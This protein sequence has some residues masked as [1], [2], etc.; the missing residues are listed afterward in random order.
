MGAGDALRRRVW[1]RPLQSYEEGGP[2][3][4]LDDRGP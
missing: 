4:M 3:T 2:G 1:Q